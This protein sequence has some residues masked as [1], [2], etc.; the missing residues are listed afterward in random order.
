MND[1]NG[2]V[3]QAVFSIVFSG[4]ILYKALSV[5]GDQ[6]LSAGHVFEMAVGLTPIPFSTQ[7][8]GDLSAPPVP[9]V[10]DDVLDEPDLIGVNGPF[11]DGQRQHNQ[12][13]AKKILDAS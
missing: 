6:D 1:R 2:A 9:I 4:R 13:I 7:N 3:T 8:P 5:E 10:I 12:R 11:S